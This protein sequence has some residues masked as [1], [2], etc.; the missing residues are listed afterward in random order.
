MFNQIGKDVKNVQWKDVSDD[1]Q[2]VPTQIEFLKRAAQLRNAHWYF[3]SFNTI[4][5]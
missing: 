3:H 1:L 4:F 5:I 2:L